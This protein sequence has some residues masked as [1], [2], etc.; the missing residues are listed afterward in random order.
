[1][2]VRPEGASE[3]CPEAFYTHRPL[4]PEPVGTFPRTRP[5][6]YGD[7]GPGLGTSTDTGTGDVL[8]PPGEAL[9]SVDVGGGFTGLPVA[10]RVRLEPGGTTVLSVDLKRQFDPRERGYFAADLHV[11]TR[12]SADGVTPV[13]TLVWAQAAADLDLAVLSDH[14]TAVGHLP[15]LEAAERRGMPYLLSE[16]VTTSAWG[17]FNP[18]SLDPGQGITVSPEKVPREYFQEARDRGATLVQVNHPLWGGGQGYFTRMDE[19]EFDWGFQL[20]EVINGFDGRVSDTDRKAIEALFALWSQGRRVVATAGSDDHNADKPTA[21]VGTPR[22]Y[23]YVGLP[24]GEPLTA[25]RWLE[26]L[27]RGRAFVTTGPLVY[28]AVTVAAG[29]EGEAGDKPRTRP[30]PGARL[31]LGPG[32]TLTLRAEVESVRELRSLSLWHNGRVVRTYPLE[33]KR[34]SVEW[35]GRARSGWYAVTV[36][37]EGGGFALTNP[38]WVEPVPPQEPPRK[39]GAPD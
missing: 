18:F 27:A 5:R 16:E 21:R 26:A 31:R 22:T 25:E 28:L 3:D 36:E 9:V 34:A 19:P 30:G 33:G 6:L 38:V 39:G 37:S 2:I 14:N 8:L 24:E 23:A 15:F 29:V 20:V 11:H 10:R 13:E 12:A 1:M 17:H 35:S 32:E 4:D 7:G